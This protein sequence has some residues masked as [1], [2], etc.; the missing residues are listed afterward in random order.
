[1]D[2]NT[3]IFGGFTS[4]ASSLSPDV[5]PE[6][7]VD[8][9][10]QR[11]A[12][13]GERIVEPP[14]SS[15]E[16]EEEAEEEAKRLAEESAATEAAGEDNDDDED[17]DEGDEEEEEE[18]PVKKPKKKKEDKSKDDDYFGEAEPEMAEYL[19]EKLFEKF[20]L[21]VDDE[22]FETF[23]SLDDVVGFVREAID[24]NSIP[25]FANQEVANIDTYV[26]NGGDLTTYM[27]N[28]HGGINLD[29]VDIDDKNVQK[30]IIKQDLL[31]QGMSEARIKR[32]IDRMEDT[33][34]LAE[35]AEDSLE[36]LKEFK[37]LQE[38]KLLTDQENANKAARENNLRFV[39][40]VQTELDALNNIRGINITDSEKKKLLSYMLKP[41]ADGT[42]QY[43]KD[44]RSHR[45]NMIE[46]AYFTMK[47]DKLIQKVEKKATSK[48]AKKLQT[49]LADK[50]RRGKNQSITGSDAS[51]A[52]SK[53]FKQFG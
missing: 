11:L 48:A 28:V 13:G 52:W 40:S 22:S 3:D 15:E 2:T 10:A 16:E 42:T 47:G 30:N 34:T 14:K 27:S 43:M 25:E 20:N 53:V 12:D 39:E 50:G 18:A 32:K 29:S 31:N 33:A 38:E 36:S 5:D 8:I 19:Q 23:K 6:G 7:A 4:L 24:A 41:T 26:R 46:S 17:D 51:D 9:A 37:E 44:Y 1:M 21:D 35:E 49:K 45:K